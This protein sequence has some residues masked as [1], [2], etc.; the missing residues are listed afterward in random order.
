MKRMSRQRYL[1]AKEI[2]L[3]ALD[4]TPAEREAYMVDAAAG[5]AQLLAEVRSLLA[6]HDER[7]ILP[8]RPF[9][10][11]APA[12]AARSHK[13][14]WNRWRRPILITLALLALT[15]FG[16]W[17]YLRTQ[18]ALET[19]VRTGLVTVLDATAA[20]VEE[21]VAQW[22]ADMNYLARTADW[23][24]ILAR[25][26]TGFAAAVDAYV[27]NHPGTQALLLREAGGYVAG[28]AALP[29]D[30]SLTDQARQRLESSPMDDA[31]FLSPS[32][33]AIWPD[34][35]D[36][37]RVWLLKRVSERGVLILS[38]PA[39]SFDRLFFAEM[40]G[41]TGDAFAF[42]R[43][44]ELISR[45]RFDQLL[46]PEGSFTPVPLR[47]PG[48]Q[49]TGQQK[50]PETW[51][52]R[53]PTRL[54]TEAGGSA[55]EGT[56]LTPYINHRG[57]RVVGAWRWLK[58]Q[59]LGV[60]VEFSAAEAF[61]PIRPIQTGLWI[62]SGLLG[63]TSLGVLAFSFVAERWKSEASKAR[64]LGQYTLGKQLGSGGMG[65]VY[66]ARHALL[67]RPAAVK[68]IRQDRVSEKN[69]QRFEREAQLAAELR[70]PNTIEVYDFG[71]ATDGTV[72][73]AMEY[74]AG[75]SL[76]DLSIAEG[77]LP[78]GRVIHFWIQACAS[79]EEAHARGVLH[80]DIKPGNLMTCIL[81]GVYD[82]IKVLD[83]G[84][85]QTLVDS[86]LDSASQLVAGTPLYMAPERFLDAKSADHRSDIYALGAV[87]YRLLAGQ[88]P[89]E[90][91]P[92][93][94]EQIATHT[95]ATPS[96][97]AGRP[98]P[99]ELESVVYACLEKVPERRP[100]SA[101][102]LR[103]VLEPFAA[104]YPWTQSQALDWW[105]TRGRS[106]APGAFRNFS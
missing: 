78:P 103:R 60:A 25:G 88:D 13:P 20:S 83:F 2:F 70:H 36:I 74:V 89:F 30:T 9:P 34:L 75:I 71:R 90:T 84:L 21:W 46:R 43:P 11:T 1:R 81:G 50:P 58:K 41:S 85:A 59:N 101:R 14:I 64:K 80:R 27:A 105:E 23:E 102:E 45:S 29:R 53:P 24:Q 95:P 15:S 61:A 47:D 12:L 94:F 31:V 79:L 96:H 10:Y 86:G 37:P 97:C 69:L 52:Q 82:W 76:A 42:R 44:G 77:P 19:V 54:A 48:Y 92:T 17:M 91:G 62:L 39:E 8:S 87:A 40:A 68:V 93:L 18:S 57:A 66:L 100:P 28:T 38:R 5:D 35:P 99:R 16:L 22:S 65:E 98:V 33:S 73:C 67:K 106:V 49:L 6:Y 3:A 51:G 56:L 55:G 63:L 72:Y 7:T 32:I 4:R 26:G 104:K